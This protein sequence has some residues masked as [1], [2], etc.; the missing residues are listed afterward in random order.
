MGKGPTE[1][2]GIERRVGILEEEMMEPSLQQE[3]R[4]GKR[5]RQKERR[6]LRLLGRQKVKRKS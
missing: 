4:E 1:I 2:T 6:S 5:E 3:K